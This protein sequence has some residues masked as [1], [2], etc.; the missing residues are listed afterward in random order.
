MQHYSSNVIDKIN[1]VIGETILYDKSRDCIIL[2]KRN[3]HSL[4][5]RK[6]FKIKKITSFLKY[7]FQC[8]KLFVAINLSRVDLKEILHTSQC[9]ISLDPK[10]RFRTSTSH[11][12]PVSR[13]FR[14]KYVRRIYVALNKIF[15]PRSR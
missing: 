10:V 9:Q 7:L 1:I 2:L 13:R 15:K 3:E 6:S 12:L 11:S 14:S 4:N 5:I 8:L